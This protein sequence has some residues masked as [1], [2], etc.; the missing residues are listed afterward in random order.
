MRH[1]FLSCLDAEVL[2]VYSR[3]EV[4]EGRHVLYRKILGAEGSLVIAIE[5]FECFW[6]EDPP[7]SS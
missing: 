4:A 2:R 7:F 3:A 6:L 5:G 1:K